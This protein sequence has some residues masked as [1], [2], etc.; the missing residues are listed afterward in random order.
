VSGGGERKLRDGDI[1]DGGVCG[2]SPDGKTL[3][4]VRSDGLSLMPVSSPSQMIKLGGH[5]NDSYGEFSPDGKYVAYMSDQNGRMEIFITSVAQPDQKWQVSNNG[6][7][8]PRWRADGKEIFYL[9]PTNKLHA[10]SVETSGGDL[11]LG[12]PQPLFSILPRPQCRPYAVS[13]DGQRFLVNTLLEQ[14]SPTVTVV[15]NWMAR[16]KR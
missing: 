11:T 16:L 8:Y 15:S 4:Y 3:L 7:F 12:T 10:A 1:T 9:D 2:I 5:T 13:A 6:G 14:S